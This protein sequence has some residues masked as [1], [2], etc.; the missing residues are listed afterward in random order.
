MSAGC[1]DQMNLEETS[2]TL[3]IGL[4]LDEQQNLVTYISSPVFN[5]EAKD[6]T[7]VA[8]LKARTMREARNKADAVLTGLTFAGKN[9]T[10]LIGKRLAQE[11]ED[12][13]YLLDVFFRDPKQSA[14]PRVILVD[15][16]VSEVFHYKPNDKPRLPIYMRTL[17]DTANRRNI[18]VS[19]NVQEFRR[20]LKDRGITPAITQIKMN[21]KQ[22][23][24]TGTS[25]LTKHGHLAA[26]LSL[27]ESAM[28]L[29][30]KEQVRDEM[31]SLPVPIPGEKNRYVTVTFN[32]WKEKVRTGYA[33]NCFQ[34]DVELEASAS[35]AAIDAEYDLKGQ[36]AELTRQT[37]KELQ[38]W[39]QSLIERCQD[40][41]VDPIGFGLYARAYQYAEWK[42]VQN[43][44][45]HAFAKS[46]VRVHTAVHIISHG[47]TD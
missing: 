29:A 46:Q 38:K 11:R 3:M 16:E 28:L 7:E 39:S 1:Y 12:W 42:K 34:F 40:E 41:E 25:L 15:G 32:K 37:E 2:L 43:A 47:V 18:T 36:E 21:K 4:D 8:Q 13:V 5:R 24:I 31:I 33:Q 14:T 35:I 23:E 30:L 44:W 27:Q 6:K 45:P 9:Q 26:S 17:V 19:T 20:Q 10:L 22:V